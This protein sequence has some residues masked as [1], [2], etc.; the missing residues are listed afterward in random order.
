MNEKLWKQHFPAFLH[1][2]DEVVKQLMDAAVVVKLPPRQQVFYPGK[3]CENYLLML[4]GS[5]KAQIIS[6]DG[7]EILLYHVLAGDSCVLT[8]SCL[9]GDDSYPAE[10][11]TE[12]EVTAFAV[13]AYVFHRCLERSA[14]FRAFV[15]RNFSK[16]LADVIKRMESITFGSVDQKL[17][18][19]LLD[20]G[21]SSLHKTHSELALE[22]GTAR[23]VVS[24]H[25]KRSESYGWLTLSRGCIQNINLQALQ[26]IEQAE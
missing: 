1:A 10:G 19:V 25:L 24:R 12:T 2:E 14:F 26:K 17:A 22:M 16:R 7:R 21:E 23:E 13:S 11:Y 3:E 6:P 15:F 4:S 18:K 8:T 5:I 20:A 9:L